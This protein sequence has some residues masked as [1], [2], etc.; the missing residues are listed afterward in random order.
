MKKVRVE[1][2]VGQTLFHDIARIVIG[3]VKD[4]PFRRGQVIREEDIPALLKL[5]K[6]H[7]YVM[8]TGDAS[9]LHEED[10]A[11]A[12]YALCDNPS[13]YGSDVREGKIE[14][15]AAHDGML[16]I[17]VD[18]L[19]QINDI[20]QLTIVTKYTQ[21]AVKKGDK[22]AGMRCI[23]LVLDKE[24]IE[25]ANAI[26]VGH[27][28]IKVLPFV[29]KKIGLVTT[30]SEVASGRIKDAFTPIIE[31]RIQ[32]YGMQIIAHETVTDDTNLIVDAIHKVKKAGADMVFCTGGMS[33]DPDDLTPGAIARVADKVVTYG[34]PVLPGSMCCIAYMADGTPLVGW[35]GGVLFSQPTAFDK[36]LPRLAADDMITKADCISMGHGG[37]L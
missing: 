30:G 35:P 10:V 18:R 7:V 27:P 25:A 34:L 32:S 37:L 36:L 14:A 23:P 1:D 31:E 26:G 19:N 11:R 4:T 5:G 17:D 20:G 16:S 3:Q 22:L 24:E 6:E 29:R 15:F 8:E 2:A 33:V 9:L 21:T 28:L 13:I 12:L